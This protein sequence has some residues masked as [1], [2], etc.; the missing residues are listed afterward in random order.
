M[1]G[2]VR[3]ASGDCFL[4]YCSTWASI[5]DVG[6]RAALTGLHPST[7]ACGFNGLRSART[8][9]GQPPGA[10][11][12]TRHSTPVGDGTTPPA[13]HDRACPPTRKAR[14]CSLH[15]LWPDEQLGICSHVTASVQVGH[16]MGRLRLPLVVPPWR[17]RGR[18]C[19]D[20]RL[21][22]CGGLQSPRNDVRAARDSAGETRPPGELHGC[23]GRIPDDG[24]VLPTVC[25]RMCF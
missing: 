17:S 14:P 6:D 23:H 5:A 21:E 16:R 19:G 18:R 25:A 12:V 15:A 9:D 24:C 11:K 10:Q 3:Y 22:A 2:S 4:G 13:A 8:W 20:V 1:R 7:M